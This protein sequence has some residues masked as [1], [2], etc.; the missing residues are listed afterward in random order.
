M[1]DKQDSDSPPNPPKLAATNSLHDRAKLAIE[2]LTLAAVVV[3]GGITYCQWRAMITANEQTKT[4]LHI[5]ERA[6]ITVG[7]PTLDTT[8]KFANFLLSNNGHIPS[9]NIEIIVHEATVNSS[10]PNAPP[11]IATAVEYHWKRHKLSPMPPSNNAF[12]IQV[13]LREFAQDKYTTQGAYQ[14]VLIAGRVFYERPA[15]LAYDNPT[16]RPPEVQG[17]GS[18][19]VRVR[20]VQCHTLE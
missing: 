11:N 20:L 8:T 7:S 6:Y 17:N 1:T 10:I 3:Y 12:G 14:G 15:W 4:A 5:S 9:G 16:K 18:F 2:A 13:P 19:V